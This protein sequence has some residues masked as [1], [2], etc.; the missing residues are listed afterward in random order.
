MCWNEHTISFGN[1]FLSSMLANWVLLG[2]LIWILVEEKRDSAVLNINYSPTCMAEAPG[3]FQCAGNEDETEERAAWI[4]WVFRR[5]LQS[6]LETWTLH[7]YVLHAWKLGQRCQK[8]VFYWVKGICLCVL[9][10]NNLSTAPLTT[11]SFQHNPICFQLL[12]P[13]PIVSALSSLFSRCWPKLL[14]QG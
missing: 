3:Y 5:V 14:K 4:V 7:S 9:T 1:T 13:V 11:L 6:E 8:K 10:H 2:W 12:L